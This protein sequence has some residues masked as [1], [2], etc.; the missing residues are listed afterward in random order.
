MS[1]PILVI[2]ASLLDTKGK[3]LAG[4]EPGTSNPGVIQ[5]TRGGTA[6]NVAENLGRYGAEVILLSALGDDI[7]GQWLQSAT[8]EAGVDMSRVIVSPAHRTGSYIAFL[9]TD[10]TLSVALNDTSVMEIITP[11]YVQ[12]YADLFADASMLFLDGSL[13]EATIKTAVE[14]ARKHKLPI[15]ADPSSVRLVH[16]FRPYIRDFKLIVPNEVEASAMANVDFAGFDPDASLE[17]ARRLE[18][19]GIETVVITLS[20]FGFVYVSQ[21]ESGY[22]P[23]KYR[24]FVDSTGTGDAITAAI[25]FGMLEQIPITECMR[26]G[27][28]AASLTLQSDES[29]RTDLSLDLL[30]DHL[31]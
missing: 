3:P 9:E 28:A 19:Q 10:G 18:R 17:V 21:D 26:L 25:M 7:S 23:A 30:Y 5:R 15:C 1:D 13:P 20:D 16:K 27:T 24:T 2:G 6:R 11:D 22:F 29:V 31:T 12:Q 8:A 14:L 4:L